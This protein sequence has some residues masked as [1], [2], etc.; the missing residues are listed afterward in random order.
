MIGIDLY[1]YIFKR[2]STRK[3]EMI[4]LTE[5]LLL[6]IKEYT[7]TVETLYPDIKVEYRIADAVKGALSAKAPHYMLITSEKK[8]GYLTNVG[9]IFQHVDLFLA[10]KGL[11]SCWLGLAKPMEKTKDELDFVIALAFGHPTE[12]PFRE[13]TQFKRKQ[14]SEISIGTDDRLVCAQLAPSATN[15][16][17]WFFVCEQEKIHCYLK[18]LNAVQAIIYEKM[19]KIDIGIAIAHLCIATK[20]FNKDFIFSS[21]KNATMLDAYTYIG[22]VG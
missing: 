7:K 15:S 3:Y 4:P 2:K 11:G 8:T 18:K 5:E 16:Q 10:S 1:D 19:N 17:N 22:T 12:S 21:K 6:E 20:H 14:L 13:T 9:F